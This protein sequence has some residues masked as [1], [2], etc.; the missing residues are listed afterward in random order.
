M[1][2]FIKSKVES[3]IYSLI[4]SNALKVG[5]RLPSER[6]LGRMFNSSVMPVRQALQKFVEKGVLQKV[7]GKGTFV[8]QIVRN[9]KVTNRI[10]LLHS[11]GASSMIQSSYY[12]PILAGIDGETIIR[13]KSLLLHGL[14]D[15]AGRDPRQEVL[16]LLNDADGFLVLGTTSQIFERI[17]R[18]LAVIDKP[19]VVL[20]HE[21]APE[22]LD[23][24]T[25]DGRENIRRVVEFL[26]GLGHTRIGCVCYQGRNS[27]TRN[28]LYRRLLAYKEVMGEYRLAV[29]PGWIIERFDLSDT[30]ALD[31]V[32][33]AA[34]RPTALVCTN[35]QAAE[36]VARRAAELLVRVP[37]DL[38]VTGYD[39]I[40]EAQHTRPSLTTVHT[41]LEQMGHEGVRRLLEKQE[42]LARGEK[43]IIKIVLPGHLVERES[44]LALS[45][46]DEVRSAN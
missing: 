10:C 18:T 11:H 29:R 13:G 16:G 41:P 42:E 9:T 24:V 6:D 12:G 37:E 40:T 30:A 26:A 38:T 22:T 8:R 44:H 4:E 28:N 31:A 20:N 15:A 46:K 27:S 17:Q 43:R 35:D 2:E 14:D 36:I 23:T 21:C 39:D 7:H 19:V 45:A 3:H 34:E 25:F 32:L 33:A 5:D 1:N